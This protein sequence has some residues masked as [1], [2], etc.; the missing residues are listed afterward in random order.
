MSRGTG[1]YVRHTE[2]C[3]VGALRDREFTKGVV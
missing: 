2:G 3:V 1:A